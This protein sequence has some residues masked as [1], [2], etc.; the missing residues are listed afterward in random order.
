MHCIALHAPPP[1]LLD[2]DTRAVLADCR[3]H[4]L[5]YPVRSPLEVPI[6]KNRIG[7]LQCIY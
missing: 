3:E 7:L 1:V 5:L 6:Q 2:L 4:G